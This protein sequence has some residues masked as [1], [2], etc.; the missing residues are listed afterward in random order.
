MKGR[1][2]DVKYNLLESFDDSLTTRSDNKQ[3]FDMN[4]VNMENLLREIFQFKLCNNEPVAFESYDS[5]AMHYLIDIPVRKS[6]QKPDV[7]AA[8]EQFLNALMD[9]H[10][11][12]DFKQNIGKMLSVLVEKHRD[13]VVE[14]VQEIS[15]LGSL[16]SAA[17]VPN[18]LA[19][20]L[21]G[22]E[23]TVLAFL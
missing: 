23:E 12:E 21:H 22:H 14:F 9:L 2:S 5:K 11:E 20:L 7:A 13:A 8:T 17:D 18:L 16:F 4:R 3:S 1:K 6:T 15:S 10:G 19:G